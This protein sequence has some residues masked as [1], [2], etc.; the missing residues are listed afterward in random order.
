MGPMN[1]HVVLKSIDH[2]G[3]LKASQSNVQLHNHFY[4]NNEA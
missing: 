4:P 2:C 1:A 3:L